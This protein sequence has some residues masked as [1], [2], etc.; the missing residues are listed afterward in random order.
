VLLVGGGSEGDAV[1][2]GVLC[3]CTSTDRWATRKRSSSAAGDFPEVTAKTSFGSF[4]G[5]A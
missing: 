4:V 1:G 2:D 3:S 5:G